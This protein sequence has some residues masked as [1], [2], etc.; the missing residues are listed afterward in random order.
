MYL[1]TIKSPFLM[2]LLTENN[3]KED[4]DLEYEN[5][6][7]N[8][9]CIVGELSFE[10]SEITDLTVVKNNVLILPK[11]LY[12]VKKTIKMSMRSFL[13]SLSLIA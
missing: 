6:I 8:D 1:K 3:L 7:S 2:S 5:K 9:S 4:N 10:K 13:L 12:G 11:V